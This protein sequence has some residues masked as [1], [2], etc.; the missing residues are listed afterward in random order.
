MVDSLNALCFYHLHQI[1]IVG[2]IRKELGQ[3]S[4]CGPIAWSV[5][6]AIFHFLKNILRT[7]IRFWQSYAFFNQFDDI[8]A[9]HIVVW[10]LTE[11]EHLPQGYAKRPDARKQRNQ[12]KFNC[13]RLMWMESSGVV[14]LTRWHAKMC[15][16]RS[17]L[18]RTTWWAICHLGSLDRICRRRTWHA[19]NRNPRFSLDASKPTEYFWRPNHDAQNIEILNN[20]FLQERRPFKIF[21]IENCLIESL[22]YRKQ[23]EMP[24]FLVRS[25]DW[26]F[27]CF[28]AN[29]W[30]TSPIQPIPVQSSTADPVNQ[31][32]P[33]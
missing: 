24:R 18:A 12:I 23:F 16:N 31:S 29:N 10:W 4:E 32:K 27:D 26:S 14:V 9:Q 2:V 5:I 7:R 13:D 6:P 20:A 22:I 19:T 1:L 33:H 28:Q 8:D 3:M 21:S 15:R 30:V 25:L 11:R 17:S